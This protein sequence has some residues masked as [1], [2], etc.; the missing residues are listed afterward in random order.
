MKIPKQIAGLPTKYYVIGA[1]VA[2]VGGVL[3]YIVYKIMNPN[4]GTPYAGTGAVGTLGNVFDQLSGG[5]LSAAGSAIGTTLYDWT[6]DNEQGLSDTYLFTIQGTTTR[7]AVNASE[8]GPTGIF[9]RRADGKTYT[10]KRDDKGNRI[11]VPLQ[12][13]LK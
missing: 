12:R 3:Y 5:A 8:V 9:V 2:A 11:A 13:P 4:A 6:H 10:L 1:A 7:G